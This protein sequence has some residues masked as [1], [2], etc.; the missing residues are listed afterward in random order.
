M[1]ILPDVGRTRLCPWPACGWRQTRCWRRSSLCLSC[2]S[3]GRASSATG[4]P[5]PPP[6]IAHGSKSLNVKV[7]LFLI[8]ATGFF[9]PL[10][11]INEW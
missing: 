7:V 2:W 8:R 10:F 6:S 3:S 5:R 9:I 4:D 1:T 11:T